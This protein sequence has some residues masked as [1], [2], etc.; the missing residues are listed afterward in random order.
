MTMRTHSEPGGKTVNEDC[1]IARRHPANHSV[2]ICALADGQ[3]GRAFGAEAARAACESAWSSA[4]RYSAM[5]LAEGAA[6]RSVIE[7]A[8]LATAATGGFTTLVA[9]A[10]GDDFAAGASSGDS[11]AFFRSAEGSEITEWTARQP[12]NPPVGS[13]SVASATFLGRVSRGGRLLLVTD[14]VW[15][16]CGYESLREAFELPVDVVA[17]H[18]RRAVLARAGTSLPDDFSL[19]VVDLP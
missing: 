16:Y 2:I 10:I 9:L 3:G 18:L 19:I 1:L 8:D 4:S 13:E 17:A 6:W 5:D 14:G 12:K 7:S 11:K 15:K